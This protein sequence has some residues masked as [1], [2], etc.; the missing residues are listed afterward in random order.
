MQM[1]G[2]QIAG[3]L[4]KIH[5]SRNLYRNFLEKGALISLEDSRHNLDS[6]VSWALTWPLGVT[7]GIAMANNGSMPLTVR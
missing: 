6:N 3:A 7:S 2:T 1:A 4:S 5:H